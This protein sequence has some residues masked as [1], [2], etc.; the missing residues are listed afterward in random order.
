MKYSIK[1]IPSASKDEIIKR[2]DGSIV[3]KVNAPPERGKANQAVM[4]ILSK[5]FNS[6]VRIVAGEK[7][8]KKIVETY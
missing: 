8:R 4:K 6:R 2:D 7:S 5:Y 1:V 3:V